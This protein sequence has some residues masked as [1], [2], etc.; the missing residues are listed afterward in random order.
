MSPDKMAKMF[1]LSNP[2]AHNLP[3]QK[4]P[5]LAIAQR[6]TYGLVFEQGASKATV[7]FVVRAD[8]ADLVYVRS[9]YWRAEDEFGGWYTKED[10]RQIYRTLVSNGYLAF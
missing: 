2:R 8:V 6:T 9:A 7:E 1:N 10:A 5:A 3:Q 4:A